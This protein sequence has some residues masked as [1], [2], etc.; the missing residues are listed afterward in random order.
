M[1]TA[2]VTPGARRDTGVLVSLFAK[3]AGR[4]SRTEPPAVFLTLGRSRRMFWG[5]LHFAGTLMPGGRLGR[6]RTELVILRVAHRR[7]SAYEWTQHAGLARRAGLSA[8]EVEQVRR[9]DAVWPMP[10]E[11]LLE[12]TD[13]LLTHDDLDDATWARLRATFDEPTSIELL[14][15]IGHYRMLATTLHTLRVQPD[16]PRSM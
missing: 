14:M 8:A 6:R 13:H 12:V 3:V 2:R 4:V 15:L 1:S 11:L 9:E 5:W 7:N 10:E 16:K